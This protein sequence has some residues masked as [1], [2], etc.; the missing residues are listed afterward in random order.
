MVVNTELIPYIICCFKDVLKPYWTFLIFDCAMAS[1][2]TLLKSERYKE[3]NFISELANT[4]AASSLA[5]IFT[6]QVNI[7][8]TLGTIFS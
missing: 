6:I 7:Q 2:R 8:V 1:E 5:E 3:E 4:R